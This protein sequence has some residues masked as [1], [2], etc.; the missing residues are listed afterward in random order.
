MTAHTLTERYVAAAMRTVP[1]D[2]RDDL[3]AELR[4]SIAD[5]VD[6][7]VDA[8]ES[9]EAAERDV[10]TGFGD[11]D[12]L[13]A[14]YTGRPLHL[15]GPRYFLDW[16]RLVILLLWIVVPLAAFGIALGQA[17]AGASFGGIVGSAIGGAL[18]VAL[19]LVFWTTLVFALVER[20]QREGGPLM[21]WSVDQ[22]PE[23]RQSGT[24]IGDVIARVIAVFAAAAALVWDHFI[25]FV[26]GIP[27]SFFAPELWP[28]GVTYAL[29]ILALAALL[30]VVVH[31]VGRW[32][33]PLAAAD[34]VLT[35]ALAVPALYLLITGQLLNPEFF[36]TV[37]PTD[38]ADVGRIVT[39]VV[40]FAIAGSAVWEV[41]DTVRKA[42]AARRG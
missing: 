22:L 35:L 8:G 30:L 37:I 26:P 36:P 28:V 6:A 20:S 2:Q 3:A 40:G 5:Q 11:P 24:G 12:K 31:V 29:V 9:R 19:H 15:I 33:L 7:R 27:I 21:A 4:A 1:D 38:G 18:T 14:G 17:L 42:I 32:T 25:G 13:A 41:I 34:I 23:P 39:I 10:L 16:K